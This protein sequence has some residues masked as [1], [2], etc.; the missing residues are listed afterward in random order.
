MGKR[1]N[2]PLLHAT[3]GMGHSHN[4]CAAKKKKKPKKTERKKYIPY[5]S[6]YIKSIN[7][8]K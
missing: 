6:I 1:M 4:C 2:D 7:R 3:W 5:E 8:K